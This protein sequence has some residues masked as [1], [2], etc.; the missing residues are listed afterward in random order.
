MPLRMILDT[1]WQL[2]VAACG[3]KIQFLAAG[4]GVGKTTGVARPKLAYLA[5]A[6]VDWTLGYFAPSYSMS[7]REWGRMKKEHSLK[8]YIEEA[9]LI[10]VP[11]IRFTTGSTIW[12]RS[13]DRP[14]NLLGFHYNFVVVDEIQ[15]VPESL[16]DVVITPQ[17]RAHDGGMLLMGQFDPEGQDGWL[18][19]K[20]WLPGQADNPKVKSWRIPTSM[21]RAFQSP[22]KKAD[23]D[24]ARSR[25]APRDWDRQYEALPIESAA[26]VFRG[27]DLKASMEAL[28]FKLG[29]GDNTQVK[30]LPGQPYVMGIDI[31]R[32]VDPSAWCV[33]MP[34]NKE[35][36]RVV[37]AGAWKLGQRHEVTAEK[38]AMLQRTFNC[39][40]VV[41]DSTGGGAGQRGKVEERDVYSA[42]YEKTVKNA[43]PIWIT[44]K[45]KQTLIGELSLALEQKRLYIPAEL[46]D[47]HRQ[48][49]TYSFSKGFNGMLSYAGPGGSDDDILM[50][51][52][53]AWR[54]VV[55]S[56]WSNGTGISLNTVL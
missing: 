12:Y 30:A 26:H 36:G 33:I 21:G 14:D 48:L 56:W 9:S 39:S 19:K 1:P 18:Y 5:L 32:V 4:R 40:T 24:F 41:V 54:A 2:E 7:I 28:R 38:A 13:L 50:A 27:E 3:A 42:F 31:G 17:L 15:S 44:P 22:E 29:P 8:P 46:T 55:M 23:L 6:N 47:L 16:I 20:Y 53:L 37:S 34:W 25:M 51:L 45:S 43:R 52:A 49:R 11:F 10:P 35:S